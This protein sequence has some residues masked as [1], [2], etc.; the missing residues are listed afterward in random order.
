[1][2]APDFLV[3]SFHRT[4]DTPGITVHKNGHFVSRLA[5]FIVYSVEAAYIDQVVAEYGP[6]G[7]RDALLTGQPGTADSC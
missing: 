2:M 7:S 1:M 6:C 4:A 5:D 3:A